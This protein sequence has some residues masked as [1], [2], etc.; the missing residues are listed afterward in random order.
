MSLLT[1][2]FPS[3][4]A[5]GSPYIEGR[6]QITD[7]GGGLTCG[8]YEQQAPPGTTF[9]NTSRRDGGISGLVYDLHLNLTPG[10]TCPITVGAGGAN[11]TTI[12]CFCVP[13][14]I[15]TV[16][17]SYCTVY[18]EN[19]GLSSFGGLGS[20][21]GGTYTLC[22]GATAELNSYID[23]ST[24]LFACSI[25]LV[26]YT[27][28]EELLKNLPD[29][30][31]HFIPIA[32][33]Y[34]CTSSLTRNPSEP[35]NCI[36]PDLRI[37]TCTMDCRNL[38][39]PGTWNGACSCTF[40][41]TNGKQDINGT[42]GCCGYATFARS[43][44]HSKLPSL[45]NFANTG[46]CVV[47]DVVNLNISRC[48]IKKI[49]PFTNRNTFSAYP[50]DEPSNLGPW[51]LNNTYNAPRQYLESIPNCQHGTFGRGVIEG[52]LEHG[53]RGYVSDITGELKEY[54]AGGLGRII[55]CFTPAAPSGTNYNAQFCNVGS[56]PGLWMK[57][58]GTMFCGSGGG[59]PDYCVSPA[60]NTSTAGTYCYANGGCPGSV[61]VQYPT[62][63]DAAVTSGPSVV[64]CSSNTPGYRTYMFLCPG[65]ITL[66]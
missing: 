37:K 6:V 62:E 5:T 12:V 23:G 59:A 44:I 35:W 64:D 51:Y 58:S 33:P 2:F 60:P 3:G 42:N 65:S 54:G 24:P 30:D 31:K 45:L 8:M 49:S 18:G 32:P 14:T 38:L 15:P 39:H 41:L 43:T 48:N 26:P 29:S 17:G 53:F 55:K 56:A 47:G 21:P 22:G 28:R 36:F 66:P 46:A 10:A 4:G 13:T 20:C 11:F 57:R 7:G 40:L 50:T 1:Q 19:G 16:S 63:Y 27:N 61:I 25:P 9:C 34:N 52:S